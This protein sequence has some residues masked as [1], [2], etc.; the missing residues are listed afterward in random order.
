MLPRKI[1]VVRCRRPDVVRRRRKPDR[2]EVRR[3]VRCEVLLQQVV[4]FERSIRRLRVLAV[5]EAKHVVRIDG[6][7]SADARLEL[8]V[9]GRIVREVCQV[10]G[11]R[12]DAILHRTCRVSS[13]IVQRVVERHLTGTRNNAVRAIPGVE[14]EVARRPACIR[15]LVSETVKAHADIEQQLR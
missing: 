3:I 11:D 6:V 4:L 2:P 7:R 9:G 14:P 8:V 5:A 1:V 12:L 13:L 10:S 15:Q